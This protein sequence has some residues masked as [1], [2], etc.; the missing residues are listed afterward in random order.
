MLYLFK[1]ISDEEKDFYRDVLVDEKNTFLELHNLLQKNLG[2][3]PSQLASFFVTNEDWEKMHEITLMDMQMENNEQAETM[4]NTTIGKYISDL[5]RRLLYVFDFFSERAF[6]IEL[7]ESFEKK[8][9]KPTPF[10]TSEQG[11][12]PA[13]LLFLMNDSSTNEFSDDYY[14][15]DPDDF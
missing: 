9:Q 2:Y 3:D 8:S 6:F 1:I 5:N 14:T 10:I 11:K 12:P 4:E 15:E 7:M 13:Q